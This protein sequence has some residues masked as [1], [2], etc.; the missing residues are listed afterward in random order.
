MCTLLGKPTPAFVRVDLLVALV[1]ELRVGDRNF[2]FE[3]LQPR[4]LS[5]IARGR[6]PLVK[7][8]IDK[9]V[10]ATNEKARHARDLVRVPALL[11]ERLKPGNIGLGDL[12][13]DL[14]GEQQGHVDVDTLADQRADRGKS[15]LGARH[16]DH[17]VPAVDLAP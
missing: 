1:G 8:V 12:G 5:R 11:G 4:L 6:D 10:D 17:Q 14:L 7:F 2:A 3:D 13:I 15:R 16:L 9:G